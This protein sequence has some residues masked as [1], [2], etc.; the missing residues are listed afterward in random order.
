MAYGAESTKRK[1]LDNP[2]LYLF[3]TNDKEGRIS[4]EY[5]VDGGKSY[6]DISIEGN[7]FNIDDVAL[8]TYQLLEGMGVF[9][10]FKQKGDKAIVYMNSKG[11]LAHH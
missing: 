2:E 10:Q 4:G 5:S 7:S 8:F 9:L 11:F 1:W 6:E 3:K